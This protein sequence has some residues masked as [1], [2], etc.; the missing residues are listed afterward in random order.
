MAYGTKDDVY[1]ECFPELQALECENFE[2]VT[3][4]GADHEFTG[5]V[6]VFIALINLL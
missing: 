4:E 6:D 3:A 2:I 5:M 1:E